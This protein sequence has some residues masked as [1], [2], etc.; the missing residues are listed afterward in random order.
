[1]L[2]SAILIHLQILSVS[3][4]PS[5]IHPLWDLKPPAKQ[6]LKT[7][8]NKKTNKNEKQNKT[9]TKQT[10][11]LHLILHL[12]QL[13]NTTSFVLVALGAIVC[14][15]VYIPFCPITCKCNC[16]VSQVWFKVSGFWYTIITGFSPKL[17]SDNPQPP[18]V[19]EILCLPFHRTST[20]ISSSIYQMGQILGQSKTRPRLL[21]WVVAEFFQSRPLRPSPSSNGW[22]QLLYVH[23]I[24][25]SSSSPW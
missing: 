5:F 24:R 1:M 19:M 6:V 2:L 11:K 21:F 15:I 17:A 20:F 12:S 14:H 13:S 9:K 25:T 23:A 8:H 4:L 7:K 18:R 22:S 16:N 10:R 3:S